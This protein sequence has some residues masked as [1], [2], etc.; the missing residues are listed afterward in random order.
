[1]FVEVDN[2]RLWV[3][4]EGA[5]PPLLFVHGGLGDSRLWQPVA[6]LLRDSFRCLRYDLRFYGRSTGAAEGWS[7]AGD[8]IGVLDALGIERAALVGL[9]MG[10]RV[11][12]EAAQ[13]HPARVTAVVHVAGA[14]V[15]VDLDPELE[16]AYEAAQ[17]PEQEMAVDFR[18][19]APLGVEEEYRELWRAT[20]QELPE[21][22]EPLPRPELRPDELEPPVYVI[23]A[24]HDPPQFRALADR[25]PAEERV[26]V[27]SDHYLTL[28]RPEEV[29]AHIRRFLGAG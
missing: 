23:T 14:V 21:G 28:R 27:D 8:A 22:A 25:L 1:M 17:T 11:A 4:D 24:R 18:V 9:S 2:A 7:S 6:A 19:W 29:A 16:A 13:A 3:E 5:G 10:G 12:L 20:P 26:E 15:P